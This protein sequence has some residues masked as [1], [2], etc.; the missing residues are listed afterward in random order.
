MVEKKVSVVVSAKNKMM[1]GLRSA[2]AALKKFGASAG[3]IAKFFA[4]SFLVA[5]AAVLAFT[6]KVLQAFSVQEKAEKQAAAAFRA[7]GEEITEN[8]E[9]VKRFA[10]AI[11]DETGIADENTIALAAN[12]KLIGVHTD[13]LEDATKATIALQKAGMKEAAA[14]RA[15]AAA[16]Q[17]DFEALQRYLPALKTATSD[18]EKAA[19]VND[20]VTKGYAAQKEELNTLSGQWEAFKGRIGD[21]LEA[22]GSVIANSGAMKDAIKRAGDAVKAYGES[23]QKWIGGGGVGRLIATWRIFFETL[24]HGWAMMSARANVALAAVADGI[25][26]QMP[27]FKAFVLSALA[28]VAPT[29]A[30]VKRAAAAVK[31]AVVKNRDIVDKR[32][33]AA[34]SV[35][36]AE[37]QKHSERMAAISE[38]QAEAQIGG[39]EDVVEANAK[40]QEKIIVAAVN[41]T[42]TKNALL[43]KEEQ[44]AK[45]VAQKEVDAKK[46]AIN[47]EIRKMEEAQNKRKEIA[48]KTVA[49]I[50]A[51]ARAQEEARKQEAKDT[52]KALQLREKEARGIK[53]GRE[54]REFLAAFERIQ[55]ARAGVAG[56]AVAIKGAR[57]RLKLL[58]KQSKALVDIK[59]ELADTRKDLNK[60]LKRN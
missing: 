47:E 16:T 52:R 44:L 5:G 45:Q 36:E 4:K 6:T 1:A 31:E 7:Y 10:A 51:E 49:G 12:L 48:G 23:V 53:L 3:R 22:L 32:T 11:Q 2:G 14:A 19:I 27:K 46:A 17:G 9:K 58:D 15:V 54:Q 35:L 42:K 59:K 21:A 25:E 28:V 13:N 29:I 24:R 38:K 20:F 56:G 60:L 8:V 33:V 55:A 18:A 41:A 43:K 40:A 39:I 34:M 57:E 30:N 26:S 37:T 50:L